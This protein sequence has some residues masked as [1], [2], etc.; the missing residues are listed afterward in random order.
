MGIDLVV[1]Y[2]FYES[3]AAFLAFL[4]G[5]VFYIKSWE[6]GRAEKKRREFAC[7]FQEAMNALSA[8]LHAGYSLEHAIKETKKDLSLLYREDEAIQKEFS[9]MVRQVYIQIPV[10]QV[11]REWAKR[12]GMEE[13]TRFVNVFV[14][15]KKSG[16][17]AQAVIRDA[18]SQIRDSMDVQQEIDT[19]LAAKKYEFRIMS[20]IPLGMIAYMK[21]SFP[22]FMG[23]LYGNLTGVGVMSI[24][25][26]AYLGACY[27][28]VKIVDIEM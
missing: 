4:P 5:A 10:E 7:Q 12:V 24:C 8:A 14:S 27:L 23:I 16:G 19:V 1:S 28:G 17:D 26:A 3:A 22:E 9:Y 18:I 21:F 11:L 15:T 6:V 20:V 25:L 13:I 2:L